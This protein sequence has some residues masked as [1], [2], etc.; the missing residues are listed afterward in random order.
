[1]MVCSLL[2]YFFIILLHPGEPT[3]TPKVNMES[4]QN[5]SEFTWAQWAEFVFG[6]AV[7]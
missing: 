6:D 4:Q 7:L 5:G 1:M 2:F 3:V